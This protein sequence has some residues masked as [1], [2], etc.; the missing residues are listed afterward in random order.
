MYAVHVVIFFPKLAR[1]HDMA[2]Q[3]FIVVHFRLLAL[4]A[5]PHLQYWYKQT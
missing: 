4:S 2:L 3:Y 1:L 5:E